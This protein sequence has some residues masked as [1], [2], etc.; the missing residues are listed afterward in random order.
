MEVTIFLLP[1]GGQ[2]TKAVLHRYVWVYYSFVVLY[3]FCN[4][5]SFETLL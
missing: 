5:S 2:L 3:N 4:D 1:V